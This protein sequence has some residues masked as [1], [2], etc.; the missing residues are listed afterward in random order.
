[1]NKVRSWSPTLVSMAGSKGRVVACRA[2]STPIC[3]TEAVWK[4][5]AVLQEMPLRQAGGSAFGSAGEDVV[6]RRFFCASCGASLDS[7]VALRGEP[8]LFDRLSE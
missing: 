2:C 6:L 7:E 1:M 4:E 8:F 5:H 3:A